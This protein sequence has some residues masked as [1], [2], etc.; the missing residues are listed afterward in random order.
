LNN[1]ERTGY[2]EPSKHADILKRRKEINLS[3]SYK[4]LK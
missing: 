3:A 4:G 1:I 2:P